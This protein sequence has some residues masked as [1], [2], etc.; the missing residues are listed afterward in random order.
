MSRDIPF[1]FFKNKNKK[2]KEERSMWKIVEHPHN[3]NRLLK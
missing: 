2:V 1:L 3:K